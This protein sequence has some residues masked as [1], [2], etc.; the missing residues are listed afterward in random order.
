M[1]WHEDILGKAEQLQR[2][3][4][5]RTSILE[6]QRSQCRK[7]LVDGA[8]RWGLFVNP[9]GYP[10]QAVSLQLVPGR[11]DT[12]S[13]VTLPCKNALKKVL[14]AISRFIENVNEKTSN[15][16]SLHSNIT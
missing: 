9:A 10:S 14:K 6:R 3:A 15:T 7:Q 8:C 2:Q 4:R 13:K 11:P 12:D 16:R 1:K 5:V